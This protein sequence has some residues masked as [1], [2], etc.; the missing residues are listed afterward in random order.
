[1]NLNL[2]RLL[3]PN[4]TE[5]FQSTDRRLLVRGGANAGKTYSIADKLL[6]QS[7]WQ[8]NVP[9]KA[10]ILRKTMNALIRTVGEIIKSRAEAFQL[11]LRI[12]ES[13]WR[14]RCLNMKFEFMSLNNQE[15]YIKAKGMTDVDFIWINEINELRENDFDILDSR[16]RGGKSKYA[17]MIGDFNPVGKTSWVYERFYEKNYRNPRKLK[18]TVFD[19]PWAKPE[20]IEE[21]KAS[22]YH[23]PNFYKIYF[24]G[25]WG[26]LEG[27]VYDWS[28]VPLPLEGDPRNGGT[29]EWFDE[30][31]YGLD[32]GFSVDPA[33]L[34]RI[35]RKADKFWVEEVIYET[36]LT[37]TQLGELMY[38][39]GVNEE[40]TIYCDSAEPKSIQ[41]LYNMGFN[42]NPCQKGPDSV[43][44]GVD[45]LKEQDISIVE[46][47]EHI[48][49]EQKSYIWKR[50]K[51][52]NALN[53][54]IEIN[55]HAMDAIRYAIDTHCRDRM[56]ASIEVLG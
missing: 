6:L 18:Y 29:L 20:E 43:R 39:R 26:E 10:I 5:I 2:N 27:V 24:L 7:V 33:A 22:E 1:M 53:V 44:T 11:P 37:N 38:K 4:H 31:F 16:I 15:D 42:A 48:V 19:N 56:V 8:P 13:N 12:N 17:Q 21:L 49:K 51:D 9:L 14:G 25:E 35:Y 3:N 45:Y 28:V 47:S 32:F 54:P 41:E 30:I 52:D 55:N 40:D 46:G 50:D 36:G 34:V 23:N